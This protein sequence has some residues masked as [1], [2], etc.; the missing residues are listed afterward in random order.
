MFETIINDIDRKLK[1]SVAKTDEQIK[2]EK[3]L[4]QDNLFTEIENTLFPVWLDRSE[5]SIR[6]EEHK[7]C[8]RELLNFLYH[9]KAL[10]KQALYNQIE[11]VKGNKNV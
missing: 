4:K 8:W 6:V 3:K 5:A 2:K 1:V 10:N 9:S 11:Y 7:K